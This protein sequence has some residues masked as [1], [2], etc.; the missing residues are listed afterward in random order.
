MQWSKTYQYCAYLTSIKQT[1]DGGF[2][3]VNGH[4]GIYL[5][6]IDSIGNVQWFKSYL[7]STGNSESFDLCVLE[8]GEIVITGEVYYNAIGAEPDIYLLRIDANGNRIWFKT[9]GYT[10]FEYGYSVKPTFDRGFIIAGKTNS[11]GHGGDD[12]VLLKADAN[13]DLLWAKTYGDSWPDEA[14]QVQTLPDSGFVFT[15]LSYVNSNNQD[16]S[17]IYVV[18]TDKDGIT[19]CGY[20]DWTPIEQTQLYDPTIQTTTVDTVAI[21]SACY[22]AVFNMSFFERDMCSTTDIKESLYNFALNIFPNPISFNSEINSEITFTYPSLGFPSEIVLNNIDGKEVARY[23]LPLWSSV[24]HLKLPRL[25]AGV[26]V[27]RLV[28]D[29]VSA[30][31]KFVISK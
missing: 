17:L 1:S 11:F 20:M 21:D 25:A 31:V 3:A 13:G 24:Q 26:Y 15:G 5:L 18:R 6:K 29:G 12:A 23:A 9:Y 16:S 10:F 14:D 22:P 8:N 30:N 2:I 4:G 27:A 19:S 7:G 28:G